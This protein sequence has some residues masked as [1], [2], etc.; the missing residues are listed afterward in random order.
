M[1]QLALTQVAVSLSIVTVRQNDDDLHV[2]MIPLLSLTTLMFLL[3]QAWTMV[4]RMDYALE[5]AL[6]GLGQQFA[7]YAK[8]GSILFNTL[9]F[10]LHL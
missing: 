8:I 5:I 1:R 6:I 7:V 2:A 3:W 4:E 10:I 9:A